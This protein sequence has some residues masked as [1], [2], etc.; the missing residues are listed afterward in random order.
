[1]ST[2]TDQ[3]LLKSWT[4]RSAGGETANVV[5]S[6]D[7]GPLRDPATAEGAIATAV[8]QFERSLRRSLERADRLDIRERDAARLKGKRA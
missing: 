6:F 5:A 2:A 1:M 4:W 3:A 8:G 7:A